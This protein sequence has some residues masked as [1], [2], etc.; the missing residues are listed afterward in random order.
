MPVF[1]KS[2][3]ERL[4]VWEH[5]TLEGVTGLQEA[6][7][8]PNNNMHP[9]GVQCTGLS[10]LRMHVDAQVTFRGSPGQLWWSHF[11]NNEI[12]MSPE[13]HLRVSIWRFLTLFVSGMDSPNSKQA[14]LT[15]NFL[16]IFLL[17]SA[18]SVNPLGLLSRPKES[19]F[20]RYAHFCSQY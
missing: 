6:P 8:R 9:G 1:L 19:L 17:T 18:S 2:I 10:I 12:S 7:F 16:F 3:S 15:K 14:S 5:N 4:T 20:K 13:P 11:S